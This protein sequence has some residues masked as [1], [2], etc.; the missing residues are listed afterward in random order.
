MCVRPWEEFW[1]L[2]YGDGRL[3]KSGTV[4]L[5][6]HVIKLEGIL[7]LRTIVSYC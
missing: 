4:E 1:M 2:K 7:V 3:T 5:T 6:S